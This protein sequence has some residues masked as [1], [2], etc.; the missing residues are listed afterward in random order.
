MD[1]FDRIRHFKLDKPHL[2]L[3]AGGRLFLQVVFILN[4][5]NPSR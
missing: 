1:I 4:V 2:L 3:Y 5:N